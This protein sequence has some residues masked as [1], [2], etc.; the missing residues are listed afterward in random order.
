MI[1]LLN[2][3]MLLDSFRISYQKLSDIVVAIQ[4]M[5]FDTFVRTERPTNGTRSKLHFIIGYK[6][7]ILSL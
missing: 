6:L 3:I 1:F 7:D 4:S 2:S 5:Y